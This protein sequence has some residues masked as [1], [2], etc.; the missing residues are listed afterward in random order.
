[1]YFGEGWGCF[2]FSRCHMSSALLAFAIFLLKKVLRA[3]FIMVYHLFLSAAERDVWKASFTSEHC[4]VHQPVVCF[5][6]TTLE[7]LSKALA[8]AAH[9]K[10]TWAGSFSVKI[11]EASSRKALYAGDPRGKEHLR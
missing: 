10:F 7:W 6:W 5:C 8:I 2:H 1:M 4:W 9:I 11:S 3:C